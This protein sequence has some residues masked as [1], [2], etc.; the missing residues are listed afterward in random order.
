M[1]LPPVMMLTNEGNFP[2]ILILFPFYLLQAIIVDSYAR[3]QR[4]LRDYGDG[5]ED[6]DSEVQACPTQSTPAT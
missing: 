1:Y 4:G 6:L 2:P 3:Y 5:G